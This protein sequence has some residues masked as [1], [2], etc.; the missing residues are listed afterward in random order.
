[1]W[2]DDDGKCGTARTGKCATECDKKQEEKSARL[3]NGTINYN[4]FETYT[5][6]SGNAKKPVRRLTD[7]VSR[8]TTAIG[9]ARPLVPL[10]LLNHSP[11]TLTVCMYTGHDIA[12]RGW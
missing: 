6:F 7:R 12:R 4:I 1:M 5:T 10:H 2:D 8:E 9:R 11:L 3:E